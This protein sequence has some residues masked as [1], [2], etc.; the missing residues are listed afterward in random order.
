MGGD[1]RKSKKN[2]LVKSCVQNV[3]A[4]KMRRAFCDANQGPVC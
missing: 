4:E 3:F 2:V 1:A